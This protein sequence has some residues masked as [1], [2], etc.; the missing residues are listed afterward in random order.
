MPMRGDFDLTSDAL[1]TDVRA[2]DRD[3][4]DDDDGDEWPEDDDDDDDDDEDDDFADDDVD[5]V[6]GDRTAVAGQFIFS[7]LSEPTSAVYHFSCH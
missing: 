1:L 4:D 5:V 7:S 6:L 2:G 3:D